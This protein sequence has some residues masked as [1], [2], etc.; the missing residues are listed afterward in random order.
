MV[1]RPR[2]L[3]LRHRI[4][5]LCRAGTAASAAAAGELS[6]GPFFERSKARRLTWRSDGWPLPLNQLEAQQY[7]K[8]HLKGSRQSAVSNNPKFV[9]WIVRVSGGLLL[10]VLPLICAVPGLAIFRETRGDSVPFFGLSGALAGV[11]CAWMIGRR[12]EK[13]CAKLGLRK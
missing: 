12:F 8:S 13:A 7:T 11:A 3:A 10:L 5:L 6:N 1:P 9:M 2:F 4:S